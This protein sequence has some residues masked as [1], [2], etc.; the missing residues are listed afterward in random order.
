MNKIDVSK[1]NDDNMFKRLGNADRYK[2][3]I[4]DK[5]LLVLF[6]DSFSFRSK[7]YED[8]GGFLFDNPQSHEY[9]FDGS[10]DL[11]T[12][13]F[14]NLKEDSIVLV[15]VKFISDSILIHSLIAVRRTKKVNIIVLTDRLNTAIFETA[16]VVLVEGDLVDE[17]FSKYANYQNTHI[18]N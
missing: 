9:Y 11:N 13:D 8:L 16:D 17:K 4:M 18:I 2:Q 15:D 3:G 7:I 5:F 14:H 6:A 10:T 12:R 1:L